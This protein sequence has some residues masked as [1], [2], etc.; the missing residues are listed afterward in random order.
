MPSTPFIGVRI[1]W[2]IIAK[3][4]DF[5]WLAASASAHFWRNS[6]TSRAFSM[7]ITAWSAK[8]ATS[9]ISRAEKGSARERVRPMTPMTVSSRNKGTPSIVPIP[10]SP[11]CV[12]QL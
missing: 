3:N 5:A 9:A 4:V 11:G 2:L 1:S 10:P 8:V 12:V 7:A 6:E